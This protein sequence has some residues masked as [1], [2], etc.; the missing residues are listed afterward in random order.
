[1]ETL[2]LEAVDFRDVDHWRWR[3]TTILLDQPTLVRQHGETLYVGRPGPTR[4]VSSSPDAR[5]TACQPP[6]AAWSAANEAARTSAAFQ[7]M[8]ASFVVSECTSST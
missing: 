1:V 4:P 3:P 6:A 8:A 7:L 2:V 5:A